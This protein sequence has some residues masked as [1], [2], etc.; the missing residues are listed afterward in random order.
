MSNRDDM[1]VFISFSIHHKIGKPAQRN[2]TRPLLSTDAWHGAVDPRMTQDQLKQ[3]S[4]FRKELRAQS[5]PLHLVPSYDRPQFLLSRWINTEAFH[6]ESNLQ[7]GAPVVSAE[8]D[9]DICRSRC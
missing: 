6:F 5:L 1:N 9:A 4:H 2:P 8:A 7:V 3:A